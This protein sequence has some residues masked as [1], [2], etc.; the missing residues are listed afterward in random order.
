MCAALH[1]ESPNYRELPLD[2]VKVR[3][4]M[5]AAIGS[6]L[7]AS[8]NH[9]LVAEQDDVL[10]GVFSGYVSE[11]FFCDTLFASDYVF[12]VAPAARGRMVGARLLRAFEAWAQE[13]G[14]ERVIPSVSS[15]L[16]MGRTYD[17]YRAMGYEPAGWMMSKRIRK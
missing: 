3:A 11:S 16:D 14:A 2:R 6:L 5:T 4:S 1:A 13:R 12:Y 15:G 17:L 9:T 8:V 7:G 10:V